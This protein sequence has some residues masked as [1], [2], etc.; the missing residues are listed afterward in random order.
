MVCCE[1]C[2]YNVLIPYTIK[3]TKFICGAHYDFIII[4]CK[5]CFDEYH[6]EDSLKGKLRRE[7][8]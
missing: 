7:N 6:K 5:D 4:V 1:K 2:G 3:K 8:P